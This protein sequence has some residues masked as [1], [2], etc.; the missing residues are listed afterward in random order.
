M[1]TK[2]LTNV[3]IL[4]TFIMSPAS[5]IRKRSVAD[6]IDTKKRPL[7]KVSPSIKLTPLSQFMVEG[8]DF[9]LGNVSGVS[10][11]VKRE[12][13]GALEVTTDKSSQQYQLTSSAL[14]IKGPSI[15]TLCLEVNLQKGGFG[16]GLLKADE[17]KWFLTKGYN[18]PGFIKENL[19][20]SMESPKQDFFLI[21]TNYSRVPSISEFDVQKVS[22]M[23]TPKAFKQLTPSKTSLL[24]PQAF[25]RKIHPQFQRQRFLA[26][27]KQTL[28]TRRRAARRFLIL[29]QRR[30]LVARRK[31]LILQRETHRWIRL[32][33]LQRGSLKVE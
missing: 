27:Q 14:S 33:A 18:T 19:T 23:I 28:I 29:K 31:T 21:F 8:K 12:S 7:R 5:A 13:S 6:I 9:C 22:F 30:I 25:K 24:R 16:I 20:I 32:R 11:T 3:F 26:R 4:L 17:T 10:N 15:V 1:K 2:I